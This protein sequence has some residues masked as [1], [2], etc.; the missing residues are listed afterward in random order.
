MAGNVSSQ[1]FT[2][3]LLACTQM[4][5]ESRIS[6]LGPLESK[7]YVTM[8]RQAL[9]LFGGDVSDWTVRGGVPLHTPG[10]LCVEG[11]WSNAAFFLTVFRKSPP[12]I[13]PT[14]SPFWPWQRPQSREPRLRA[15]AVST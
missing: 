13:F 15:W 7:P 3:L 5:G 4:P 8:T 6:V 14:W 12:E 10:R 9:A 2:G 11:D 1:F